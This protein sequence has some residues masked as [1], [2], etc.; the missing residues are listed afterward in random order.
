MS[1]NT[2][3]LVD[4]NRN[5]ALQQ[6]ASSSQQPMLAPNE[7]VLDEQAF[8]TDARL[9]RSDALRNALA[10]SQAEVER[11]RAQLAL[12]EALTGVHVEAREDGTY[13]CG[14]YRDARTSAAHWRR[15]HMNGDPVGTEGVLRYYVNAPG[16]GS[17]EKVLLVYVGPN[18]E[19]SDA[20]VLG[21]L[22]EHFQA[23]DMQFKLDNAP[24]FQQ[25]LYD[26][27]RGP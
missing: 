24:L 12:S 25:R 23:G 8:G 20:D 1:S 19:A 18:R 22:P 14:L 7:P 10:A 3:L 21:G 13:E 26:A 16:I 6:S 15:K 9:A 27:L 4:I 11:L 2:Q 5:P 17:T